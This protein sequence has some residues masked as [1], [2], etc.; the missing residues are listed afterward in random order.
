MSY[1]LIFLRALV[2]GGVC[3]QGGRMGGSGK[4]DQQ[5]GDTGGKCLVNA[6][7]VGEMVSREIGIGREPAMETGCQGRV[8]W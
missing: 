7:S 8:G 2:K 6:F 3:P 4:V 5:L 1:H